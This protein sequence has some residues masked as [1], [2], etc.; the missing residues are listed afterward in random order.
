MNKFNDLSDKDADLIK[1]KFHDI[2]DGY[3]HFQ[4]RIISDFTYSPKYKPY[5]HSIR[6][7]IKDEEHLLEKIRRKNQLIS[8]NNQEDFIDKDNFFTKITDLVGVRV[9]HLYLRHFEYIHRAILESLANGDLALYEEPKAYTWDIESEEYFKGL[10]ISTER[11]DSYYTSVH[12][13]LKPRPDSTITCEV[14]VRT[15]L[16]EAWGEIDHTINY[17]KKHD[18]ENCQSQL[19]VLA[20]IISAGGHLSNSIMRQYTDKTD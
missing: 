11:K 16:E 15:L 5:V 10:E 1:E 6:H 2:L 7:R 9:L 8:S 17:P 13:V 14:Q 20:R 3:K 19:K 18:D 12:Y 4:Q